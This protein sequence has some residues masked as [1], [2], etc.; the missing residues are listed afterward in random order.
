MKLNKLFLSLISLS[1]LNYVANAQLKKVDELFSSKANENVDTVAWISNANLTLGINQGL[2]HNWSAGG[3]LASLTI[4][5]NFNG[6]LTR[7]Y[8]RHYWSNNLDANYGLFYAYSN[9][10]IPRKTDDRIDFTSKYGYRITQKSDFYATLLFNA[11]SQFTKAYNYDID[12]WKD[13]STSNFLSPLYLTISPGVEYRKGTE[14]SI[15]FSPA[16]AR[17]TF[18]D[19]YY[20]NQFAEGAFGVENG[21]NT[22]FELGAYLSARYQKEILPNVTYRGRLDL[23]SNY[24][25][26][27]VYNESNELVKKDNPGNIDIMWDNY[28]SF[29]FYKYFAMNFGLTAIYDNDVPFNKTYVDN[30]VVKDIKEPVKGLGWWQLKQSFSVGFNYKF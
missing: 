10:F 23:Y 4:N 3:E 25:A 6:N 14:F 15:F 21:K 19:K 29:K 28:L 22:R 1:T 24:L 26:K 18:V 7:F 2:L 8:H 5:G 9:E 27:D 30:G 20:T 12:N 16:A 13:H 11:K 17:Y